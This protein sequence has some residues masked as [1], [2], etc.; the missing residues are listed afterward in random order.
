MRIRG[1]WRATG[2]G[3]AQSV[4]LVLIA[5]A[6]LGILLLLIAAGRLSIAEITVG[7]AAGAAARHAA[8]L[9][10][11]QESLLQAHATAELALQQSGYACR[12]LHVAV[13]TAGLRVP[14]G[15]VGTVSVTVTCTVALGDIALPGLP[16]ERTLQ[17]SAS[18]P[19]DAYRM[20]GAG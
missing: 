10:G 2:D 19:V 9:R 3:G 1:R 15:T 17:A 14:V 7:H 18:S 8:M 20:R 16:G 13:D 5:P 4:E 11:E 12:T 6:L